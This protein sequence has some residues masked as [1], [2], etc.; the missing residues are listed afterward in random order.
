[1]YNSNPPTNT[2][3]PSTRKLIKSTILAAAV[4]GVLLVTVVMPAEYGIDPT[5][6]GKITGLK[7]MGEI[8]TSLAK[9]AALE[10]E[11]QQETSQAEVEETVAE[12][13][14]E[15]VPELVVTSSVQTHEK[16]ITL[17]PDAWTEIKLEMEK[18]A[19]VNYTWF[20]DAGRANYDTHGDSKSLD[21]SYHGYEKGSKQRDEGVLTAKFSGNHG[22]YWRNR[23]DE[24]ITITLKTTG[25]YQNIF[26]MK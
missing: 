6:V 10:L 16:T 8:K 17:I 2:D 18:D 3:L 19:S 9:D 22:W 11:K 1:M 24:T 5:G 14:Q 20:T 21:I 25:T 12:Q 4:A 13:V 7:K 23:T 15:L 26:I